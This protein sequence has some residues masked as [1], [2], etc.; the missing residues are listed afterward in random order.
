MADLEPIEKFDLPDWLNNT[1]LAK[2]AVGR[3]EFALKR[4]A[5]RELWKYT[6]AQQII[7][8]RRLPATPSQPPQPPAG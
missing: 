2:D 1:A 7:D 3:Y 8:L 5:R 4:P 6:P